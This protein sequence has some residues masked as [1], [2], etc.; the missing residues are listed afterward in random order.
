MP[1]EPPR[2]RGL[3]T[4]SR[5]LSEAAPWLTR[6]LCAPRLEGFND[7]ANLPLGF[8]ATTFR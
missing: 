1:R 5:A 3:T 4:C 7:T 6:T 2:A 8:T